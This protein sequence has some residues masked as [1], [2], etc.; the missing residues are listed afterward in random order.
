MLVSERHFGGVVP[1]I[2]NLD[3]CNPSRASRVQGIPPRFTST[4]THCQMAS[5]GGCDAF[6]PDDAMHHCGV[7]RCS[8]PGQ[9]LW[10]SQR[11]P[12]MS[13]WKG[14]A[15]RETCCDVPQIPEG[16]SNVAMPRMAHSLCHQPTARLM[17]CLGR[18]VNVLRG[19]VEPLPAAEPRSQHRLISAP[20]RQGFAACGW[21]PYPATWWGSSST[22]AVQMHS[23]GQ[24]EISQASPR[25][26]F[27]LLHRAPR[28]MSP[29]RPLL[30]P[31]WPSPPTADFPFRARCNNA[32]S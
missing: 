30:S 20:H 14:G 16:C 9:Y 13:N 31:P 2:R 15:Q 23:L 5:P 21:N 26:P 29:S 24:V 6:Y 18:F 7:I 1:A 27:P 25:P 22:R 17:I 4:A 11:W 19:G 28:T 12:S 32:P 8:L 3:I 10:F